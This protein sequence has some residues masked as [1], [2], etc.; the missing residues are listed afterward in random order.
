MRN[1]KS[2]IAN[3]WDLEIKP[4]NEVRLSSRS[5]RRP[6]RFGSITDGAALDSESR[7]RLASARR[8]ME[9]TGP[10]PIVEGPSRLRRPG[11]EG[12]PAARRNGECFSKTP[13]L[14]SA[15][16]VAEVGGDKCRKNC[17]RGARR[18]T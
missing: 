8:E 10:P 15:I 6:A 1:P 9:P 5:A 4:N 11:G 7:L 3:S 17:G 12:R 2:E 13:A 18:M 16:V 14:H